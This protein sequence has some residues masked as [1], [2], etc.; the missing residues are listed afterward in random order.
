[1]ECVFPTVVSPE[2]HSRQYRDDNH[3]E[4]AY[5]F[6]IIEI[7]IIY[8]PSKM[9]FILGVRLHDLSNQWAD[10]DE[11]LGVYITRLGLLHGVLFHF[12]SEPRNRRLEI[13]DNLI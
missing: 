1:M 9:A 7:G 11:T 8:Q 10:L 3:R 4:D 5:H 12:R 6:S 2:S 13:V